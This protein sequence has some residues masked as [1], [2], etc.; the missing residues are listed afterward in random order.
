VYLQP[1]DS[2]E[3]WSPKPEYLAVL[4]RAYRRLG[5]S[6]RSLTAAA[7]GGEP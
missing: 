3:P 5:F 1:E 6:R 7:F 4:V 2:F